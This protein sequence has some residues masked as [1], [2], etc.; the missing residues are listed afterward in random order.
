MLVWLWICVGDYLIILMCL[1]G[2]HSKKGESI[3]GCWLGL[4]GLLL[5]ELVVVVVG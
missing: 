5:R 1:K 2:R 3:M 4:L